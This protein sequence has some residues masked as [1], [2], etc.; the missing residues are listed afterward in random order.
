MDF[1]KLKEKFSTKSKEVLSEKK[2]NSKYRARS[3]DRVIEII[4]SKY[5]GNE[6][7]NKSKINDLPL[8]DYMKSKALE[9]AGL[10]K[11]TK[12][13]SKSKSKSKTKSKSKSRS[14][15]KSKN[16]GK[17]LT[18]PQRKKLIIELSNFMGLGNEKASALVDEGL[19]NVNQ[20]HMKKWLAKLPEETKLWLT[21][22][23]KKV[24]PKDDIK[25]IE[26]IILE[27]QNNNRELMLVGSYRRQK[28]TSRDIDVMIIS[29]EP[30][31][32]NNFMN[33]LKE[34]LD[35]KAYPYSKGKDK[36]SIIIDVTDLLGK[37]E[38]TVYKLDAFRVDPENK[39]PMLLYSTGSKEHNILMRGIAKKK[40]MLLNQKGLFN[41]QDD[42]LVKIPQLDSEEDYFTILD[43]PY[44]EPKDRL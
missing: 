33:D 23:P 7:I 26:P 25:Q 40:G 22:D 15:S 43:L 18:E 31:A 41:I 42:S 32:I 21:L 5:D 8:S 14:K 3:Y 1:N 4:D 36:L 12:S 29:D 10:I 16:P 17:R 44:K 27:L 34:K 9:F 28:N 2:A 20:L 11:Q 13:K 19:T 37:T 30:D 24:I 38:K 39:I 35:G 6:K